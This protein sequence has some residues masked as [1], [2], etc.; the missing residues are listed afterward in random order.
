MKAK[1]TRREAKCFKAYMEGYPL[2]ECARQAGSKGKDDVSLRSVAYQILQ[3][4][5][6]DLKDL[7]FME[8]LTGKRIAEKINEGLESKRVFPATWQGKITDERV[9]KDHATQAKYLEILGKMTGAFV[10]KLDLNLTG[11]GNLDIQV[12]SAK[13]AKNKD[14]EL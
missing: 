10:D 9:Y 6:I 13:S 4:I 14:L 1:L 8:G 5:Q 3:G 7:L 2:A 12:N 11:S